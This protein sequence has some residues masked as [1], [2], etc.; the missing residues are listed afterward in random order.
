MIINIIAPNQKSLESLK[1]ALGITPPKPVG[2]T[3]LSASKGLIIIIV[4]QQQERCF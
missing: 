3:Y 1:T 4:F 2:P